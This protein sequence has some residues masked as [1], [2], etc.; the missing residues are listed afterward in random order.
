[1]EFNIYV[2]SLSDYNNG[3]LH[4]V[5]ITLDSS[6]DKGEIYDEITKMLDASPTAKK[7]GELAEEYAI[8]DFEG[9]PECLCEEYQ[10][11]DTLL[12]FIA[13]YEEHGEA[14]VAYLE[15]Y[16]EQWATQEDFEDRFAGEYESEEDY[17]EQ[18]VEDTGML[19]EVPDQ[20][21]YYFDMEKFARD[22]FINDVT[23]VEH[24]GSLY[25]FFN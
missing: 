7:Y 20:L 14:W 17:A 19:S 15:Y 18:Y 10:D 24:N 5:W 22:M 23:G 25:V 12:N 6:T 16:G 13:K 11:F 2:A 3:I 4:G 21:K 9:F 1:M 8:H